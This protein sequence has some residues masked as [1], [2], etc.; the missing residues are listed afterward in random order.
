MN[1]ING[2][3]TGQRH[4]HSSSG[5]NNPE[6]KYQK[7]EVVRIILQA[8][9][10]LGY[11][12]SA[13]LLQEES[14]FSFESL[15]VTRF[16][17]AI[18]EGNWQLV[19]D[20]VPFLELNQMS[21]TKEIQF[22]VKRQKFLELLISREMLKALKV[23]RYELNPLSHGTEKLHQLS[24]LLM[25]ADEVD[26]KKRSHIHG[27]AQ[28]SREQLWV[29]LQ[30]YI[31]SSAMIPRN[32]LKSLFNQAI[33]YQ[34]STCH[35][36][37]ASNSSVTLYT[38]HKCNRDQFPG[39]TKHIFQGHGDEVWYVAFSHSGEYVASGSKDKSVIIWSVE[40]KHAVHT[41]TEHS[42]AVCYLAWSPDDT[43]LL[44]CCNDGGVTLWDIRTGQHIRAFDGHSEV[45]ACGWLPDNEHFVTGSCDKNLFLWDIQ[46]R[47]LHKWIGDRINGVAISKDGSR[48]VTICHERKIHL[49]DLNRK[50]ELYHITEGGHI[51]TLRLSND[52]RYVIVNLGAAQEIH[53]WDV[54]EKKLIQKFVGFKQGRF[55]IRSCMGGSNQAFV[56]SGSEDGNIYVWH[57]NHGILIE[58]LSGHSAT[59]NCVHWNPANPY[60]FASAS[61]DHT[62]RL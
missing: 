6:E 5:L 29:Q 11:G 24:S 48:M 49:Y 61:D 41:L 14:G 33:A 37:D 23:L 25:C 35:Y 16:R 15:Q 2:Y 60:M 17:Q 59:V 45:A 9:V 50:M 47:V 53:L 51:T 55:I 8:L 30:S 4:A 57:R 34:H 28:D 43:M 46:G 3:L 38:D 58:T 40:K 44:T 1:G 39:T 26:V 31:S 42:D 22:L 19:E 20:L 13:K 7:E 27:T 12:R 36:H 21:D 62:V 18:M 10:D 52:G 54:V 56:A 32:R